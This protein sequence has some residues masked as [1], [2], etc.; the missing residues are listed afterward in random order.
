MDPISISGW[1]AFALVALFGILFVATFVSEWEKRPAVISLA[2]TMAALA[3][4]GTLLLADIPS[5]E[6]IVPGLILF[7]VIAGGVIALPK[8]KSEG[9]RVVGERSRVDERDVVL[10]RFYRIEE[11]T[12]EFE[13]Y[14]ENHPEKREFDE[15]L[16]AMP[17]LAQRGSKTYDPVTSGF[18]AA[19]FDLT[20]DITR[21]LDWSP[22]PIDGRK[23]EIDPTD[24]AMR[25]KGFARYLGAASVG[26]TR[27]DPAHVYSNIGRS[28]GKWGE[29]ID[30]SHTHAI[31][32]TVPMAHEMVRLAPDS[33]T[34]TETALE[35]LQAARIAMVLARYLN[36]LGYEARAHVDGNYRVM[37][38]PVAVDAGLGELGRI[39][40]LV[41]PQLGPRV[42]LAVVTTDLPLE[43]DEPITFGVQDF[44]RTCMKCADICPSTSIDKGEKLDHSG[45]EKWQS[46]QDTCYRYWRTAG[47]DCGLC[48][49][50]CPYSHPAGS[51]HDMVR[52]LIKRNPMARRL[53][54]WS[55]DLLY[56]RR[57]AARYPNPDWHEKN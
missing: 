36:K 16:R 54:L 48:I 37:C 50:V 39:G 26:C 8:T 49:K 15:K 11:G 42:R 27:L 21:D 47:S 10:S 12:P 4:L 57:P 32:L 33:P 35:Y 45:V 55:D 2:V 3:I 53:A 24:A 30:L 14:Y 13:A 19:C 1:T 52:W 18:Q 56:G 38:V 9:L 23:V 22:A 44:C 6:W 46:R 20:E 41:T 17:G 40:L 29:P 5:R 43:Q 31:A 51:A 28:P 34:T 7:V 25:L